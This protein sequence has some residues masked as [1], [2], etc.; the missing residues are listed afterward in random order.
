MFSS[1][2]EIVHTIL[3]NPCY[4]LEDSDGEQ[5]RLILTV[6]KSLLITT[7]VY[8]QTQESV[9]P[10][11]SPSVF[12]YSF[13]SETFYD[14]RIQG[15]TNASRLRWHYTDTPTWL[16]PYFGV[17]YSKDLTNGRAPLL[18]ENMI[19]PVIGVRVQPLSFLYLF[20]EARH[21]FRYDNENRSDSQSEFR[22]GAYA[23]HFQDFKNNIFNETYAELVSV[24]RVSSAPVGLIWNKLGL[25]YQ[26]TVFF[27]PD[28]FIEGFSKTS[29]DLGYGPNETELRIGARTTFLKGFWALSLLV[30]YAPVSDVRVNGVDGLLVISRESF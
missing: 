5:M 10:T 3:F 16:D 11:S 1:H 2:F 21:L 18:A 4:E 26:P 15:A 17:V 20:T 19:A 7:C 13:Y 28:I 6:L 27:R 24:S 23:Y 29:P 30:N 14:E 9:E 22:F 12:K 8:A 25:R